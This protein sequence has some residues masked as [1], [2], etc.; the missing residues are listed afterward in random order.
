MTLSYIII[1]ILIISFGMYLIK[2]DKPYM[3][4]LERIYY[5]DALKFI[6]HR[7]ERGL[8]ASVESIKG[9]LSLPANRIYKI[10]DQLEQKGLIQM[11]SA[12][13]QLKP[14]GRPVVIEIIRAHRLWETYLGRETDM[15]IHQ[16]HR[17][18]EAKEHELRGDQLEALNAHLGFPKTDPHGDPI[19][20]TDYKIEKTEI[21]TISDL[22]TGDKVLIRHI[23]D[24]PYKISKKLFKLGLRPYQLIEV[25]NKQ[26][27]KITIKVQ[28]KE[29]AL[30][31]FE[32]MNIQVV[33]DTGAP[34][35]KNKNLLDLATNDTGVVIGVSDDIQGLARRRLLDLGITPGAK[36]SK[37][38]ISSFGGDPVAYSIR[39]AKIA[40]RKEQA[41][42]IFIEKF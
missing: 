17:I 27:G 26:D 8:P 14:Q 36:I 28:D 21:K 4:K 16:I 42:K 31:S 41:K 40:L 1:G 23:E 37:A 3:D 13:I 20:T 34:L 32:A 6:F 7:N 18:A 5:E 25:T 10:L 30:N 35:K 15:P 39:G 38:M 2:R 29:Y 22:N 11:T 24:E 19:P 12:G 9:A 33:A